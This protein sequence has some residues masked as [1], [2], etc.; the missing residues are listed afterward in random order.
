MSRAPSPKRPRRPKIP[1]TFAWQPLS[2]LGTSVSRSDGRELFL[3][4][5]GGAERWFALAFEGPRDASPFTLLDDHAHRLI[6][7]FANP[8]AAQ[9]AGEGFAKRWLRGVKIDECRCL[10]IGKKRDAV[11]ARRAIRG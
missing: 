3:N 8:A 9:R 6:G 5:A 1:T 11:R 2:F 10:D 4:V 7:E